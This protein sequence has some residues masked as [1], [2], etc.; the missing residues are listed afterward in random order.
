MS[1]DDYRIV[2]FQGDIIRDTA[3]ERQQA[4]AEQARR[5]GEP[6]SAATDCPY[7]GHLAV[8]WLEKPRLEPAYDGSPAAQAMRMINR[9]I[10]YTA[11][12]WDRPPA[13]RYDPPAP[14]VR[15]CVKCNYRWGQS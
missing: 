15:V 8:H 5:E 3:A 7:C 4:V 10:E 13:R 14:I 9:S 12:L 2:N 6:F 11:A 1:V